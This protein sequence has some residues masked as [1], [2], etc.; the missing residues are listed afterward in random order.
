QPKPTKLEVIVKTPSGTTRN[1]RECQEIVA[2]FNQ[3]MV[4]LEQLPEGDGSGPLAINPP[5]AGKYRWKGPATLVFTPRDTLPYGTSY[6]VRVPAGTK[7]LSGQLLEKDVSWSFETPR[8][9]LSSS[10][11]Y[12]N[13]ENVDLKPLI[14]LFFNQ[15]MDT[16][17]AARF[18]SVRYE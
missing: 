3:P 6:T 14:L 9:L 16:A 4:P 12:N 2:G 11:P 7:S 1:L 8:V 15:P 10:Q 13:Q 17:K 18:I 5:L